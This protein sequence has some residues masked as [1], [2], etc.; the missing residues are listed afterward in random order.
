MREKQWKNEGE[1]ERKKLETKKQRE[2]ERENTN[3]KQQPVASRPYLHGVG[4][5]VVPGE[6]Q[7]RQAR[8]P[9][10]R[11]RHLLRG[12]GG[13]GGGEEG[14]GLDRAVREGE[15]AQ[16]RQRR[17]EKAESVRRKGVAADVE[18]DRARALFDDLAD[19]RNCRSTRKE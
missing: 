11:P 8:R 2:R 18:V 4:P 17:R 19:G 10:E 13:E 14:R 15:R 12:G 1:K 9:L 3:N 16:P 6:R 5:E 7:L